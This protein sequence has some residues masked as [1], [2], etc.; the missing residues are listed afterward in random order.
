MRQLALSLAV[1][2]LAAAPCAAQTPTVLSGGE[3]HTVT[4]KAEVFGGY[5]YLR[6][7][8]INNNGGVGAVTV[9]ANEWLGF[10]GEFSGYAA[11]DNFDNNYLVVAGPK[12]TYR[13]GAV[14]PFVHVLAGGAFGGSDAA[15]AIVLGG[16]V[17]AKISHNVSIRLI[18]A[19]YVATTFRSNNGR[20]SAGIVFRF[21]HR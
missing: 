5:S 14:T 7:Y 17:D 12:F 6:L 15:G 11:E 18:Q 10:T 21:G 13:R 2:L 16:G 3:S 20:F 8:G 19:D 9:N 4:P 1:L